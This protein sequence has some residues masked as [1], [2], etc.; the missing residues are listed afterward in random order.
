MG[1]SGSEEFEKML[2]MTTRDIQKAGL[3]SSAMMGKRSPA[4]AGGISQTIGDVS[5]KLRY[6]DYAR[7]LQGKQ[8]LFGQGRGITEGVR[9]AGL[10]RGQAQNAYNIA[11][12]G[13]NMNVDKYNSMLNESITQQENAMWASA[14]ES[15]IGALGTGVG[16][17]MSRDQQNEQIEPSSSG[18]SEWVQPSHPN[19]SAQTN[20]YLI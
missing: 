11:G 2:G 15:G 18:G 7:A 8:Y 6:E 4:V 20:E 1:E 3:E 17:Y 9:S 16:A 14:M 5:G 12:A 13:V 10:T 19:A